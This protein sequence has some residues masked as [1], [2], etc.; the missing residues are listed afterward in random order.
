M[1]IRCSVRIVAFIAPAVMAVA[2]RADEVTAR[3][4]HEGAFL[5]CAFWTVSALHHVGRA[6]QAA[7]LPAG[8]AQFMEEGAGA[9][10]VLPGLPEPVLLPGQVPQRLEH[11][12]PGSGLLGPMAL[13]IVLQLTGLTFGMSAPMIL[14]PAASYDT[15]SL[16]RRGS[17]G[18]T[19]AA[20]A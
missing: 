5:A 18:S 12:G 19:M 7:G 1:R 17:F 14:V 3:E 8:V 4:E 20:C 16:V 2:P 10:V 11:G 9:L 6:D 15:V 13:T